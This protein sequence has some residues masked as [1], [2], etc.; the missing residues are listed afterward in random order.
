MGTL[1]MRL[2][3]SPTPYSLHLSPTDLSLPHPPCFRG[4]V[5]DRS[6]G[7]LQLMG[8]L[9]MRL[10]AWYAA[11]LLAHGALFGAAGVVVACL[12]KA[13]FLP[14]ASV[15]VLLVLLGSFGAAQVRVGMEGKRRAPHEGET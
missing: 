6:S 3:S 14:N 4:M 8:T 9:G 2:P 5:S 13:T 1:G 10:P 7:R 12:A 15:G 11:W